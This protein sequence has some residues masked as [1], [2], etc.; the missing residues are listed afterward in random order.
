MLIWPVQIESV[1]YAEVS[2]VAETPRS[3]VSQ[4][5]DATCQ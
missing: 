5:T 2:A 1:Y 3:R 4:L